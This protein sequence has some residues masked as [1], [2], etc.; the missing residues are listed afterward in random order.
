M[1][2]LAIRGYQTLGYK[3]I[4]AGCENINGELQN[5]DAMQYQQTSTISVPLNEVN[6]I[7]YEPP[8]APHIAAAQKGETITFDMLAHGLTQLSRYQP[9]FL[10]TEGAGGWRLPLG[11][12]QFLSKFPVQHDMKII[13]VVGLRLGCLNH[14]LLTAEAIKADGGHFAGWIGNHIDPNMLNQAENIDALTEHLGQ[15]LAIIPF[16]KALLNDEK[17]AIVDPLL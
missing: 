13:L 12:G 11:N 17:A 8:I 5:E 15:P 9:D 4:S 6:P 2:G 10:V 1:Q 14:A 7:A 16:N 3:P